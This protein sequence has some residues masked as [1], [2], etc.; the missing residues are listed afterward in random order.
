MSH[1]FGENL[2]VTLLFLSTVPLSLSR[3]SSQ[4]RIP[5]IMT[6]SR[7]IENYQ[8]PKQ[9]KNKQKISDQWP[10]AATTAAVNDDDHQS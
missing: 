10:S 5:K 7:E 8:K 2:K 3:T 6:R 4:K 1:N 9:D